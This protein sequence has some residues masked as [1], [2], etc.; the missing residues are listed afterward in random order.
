MG[1][2][3]GMAFIGALENEQEAKEIIK[4][5]ENIEKRLKRLEK[6][7]RP[8]VHCMNLSAETKYFDE[9]GGNME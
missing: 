8:C 9:K 7:T 5:I 1:L 6:A 4:R 2:L 3:S